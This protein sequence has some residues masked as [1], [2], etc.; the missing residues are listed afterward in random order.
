MIDERIN[1]STQQTF[2]EIKVLDSEIK[3]LKSLKINLSNYII[4]VYNNENNELCGAG[5]FMK[6]YFFTAVQL[7]D[8]L[9]NTSRYPTS[10]ITTLKFV[11]ENIK[12][13]R[14]ISLVGINPIT[15]LPASF[16]SVSQAIDKNFK[17]FEQNYPE[18]IKR[19]SNKNV[20]DTELLSKQNF[21]IL[22]ERKYNI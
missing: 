7:N 2:L 8:S 16:L 1:Y 17:N 15:P 9:E 18:V 10:E 5:P 21:N 3:E 20:N 11:L 13:K 6:P 14:K 12:T 22:S 19:K 4:L